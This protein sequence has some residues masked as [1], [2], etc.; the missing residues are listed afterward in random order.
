MSIRG[1]CHRTGLNDRYFYE[2]FENRDALL[3]AAWHCVLE[4]LL[5][6]VTDAFA[7]TMDRPTSDALRETISIV[8]GRI[9]DDPRRAQILLVDHG[10]NPALH[11]LRGTA[12]LRA[13]QFMIVTASPRLDAAIDE[14]ALRIDTFMAIAGFIELVNATLAGALELT[15]NQIVDHVHR[16]G[17]EL[18][19]RYLPPTG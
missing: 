17:M 8:V 9:F 5:G 14:D 4:E 18:A 15:A 16:V 19:E 13:S 10:N 7:R 3:V 11:E 2:S 1:V 6:E 12:V